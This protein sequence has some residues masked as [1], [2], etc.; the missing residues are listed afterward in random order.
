MA[1]GILHLHV[2]VVTLF[3]LLL[4]V[5]TVLLL[6]NSPALD[7]VREKT[8]VLDMVFGTFILLTG[9]YLIYATSFETYILVKVVV[10]LVGIPLGIIGFKRKIKALAVLSLLLFVYV[11]GV[12]E[13]K[14]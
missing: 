11:Y 14:S 12:A 5:K 8:K 6:I 4:L 9:G 2:T 1:K 3:L 7:K 13:T 10:T